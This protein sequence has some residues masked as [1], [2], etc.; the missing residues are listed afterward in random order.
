MFW[1]E[2]KG[3]WFRVHC[4]ECRVYVAAFK[5]WVSL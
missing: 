5:V 2:G 3:L 4:L 1:D